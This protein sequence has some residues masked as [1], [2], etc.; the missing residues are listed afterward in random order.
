MLWEPA[1][2][3]IPLHLC[4]TAL[5]HIDQSCFVVVCK[6]W[7]LLQKSYGLPGPSISVYLWA[8]SLSN[9][10]KLSTDNK[11]A[12][13]FITTPARRSLAGGLRLGGVHIG[14]CFTDCLQALSGLLARSTATQAS[15]RQP[16]L[17]AST[18]PCNTRILSGHV[19]RENSV[20][21]AS[22]VVDHV[23]RLPR[24]TTSFPLRCT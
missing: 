15:G 9:S 22:F 17:Q 18:S 1:Q 8:N 20:E 24:S 4:R 21:Y 19:S 13:S 6:G 10:F 2:L 11:Q 5:A 12:P 3:T 23:N 16:L 7:S 14:C